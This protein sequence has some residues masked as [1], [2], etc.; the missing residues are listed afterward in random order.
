MIVITSNYFHCSVEL[1]MLTVD[2]LHKRRDS[3]PA[4]SEVVNSDGDGAIIAKI[5]LL[6]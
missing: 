2:R 1:E 4:L 6:S 5:S 3:R